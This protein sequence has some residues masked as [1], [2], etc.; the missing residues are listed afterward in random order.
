MEK[1]DSTEK[2]AIT[3][4]IRKEEKKEEEEKEKEKEKEEKEREEGKEKEGKLVISHTLI[5][6]WIVGGIG[7]AFSAVTSAVD[8]FR[9]I[10]HGVKDSVPF[11]RRVVYGEG[12][13]FH[14][15]KRERSY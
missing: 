9:Q 4:T 10:I 6:L 8:Q 5:F 15:K 3:S 13:S 11:F 12:V 14:E 2:K 7:N 1:N